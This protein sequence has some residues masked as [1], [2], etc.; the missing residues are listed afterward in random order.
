MTI[1]FI[2][3]HS[4]ICKHIILCLCFFPSGLGSI[5]LCAQKKEKR[6]GVQKKGRSVIVPYRSKKRKG[7]RSQCC[8]LKRKKKK[9]RKGVRSQCCVLKRKKKKKR[10]GVRSLFGPENSRPLDPDDTDKNPLP[11]FNTFT[12]NIHQNP[13]ELTHFYTRYFDNDEV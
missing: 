3:N 12:R 13:S 5:L 7:V 1:R 9:K 4:G 11:K 6:K 10:K 2:S 8:V